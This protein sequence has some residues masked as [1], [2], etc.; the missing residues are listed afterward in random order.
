V[1]FGRDIADQ[2]LVAMREL[3]AM[4]K[5]HVTAHLSELEQRQSNRGRH[6]ELTLCRDSNAAHGIPILNP[7][8]INE[9]LP[10]HL[11]R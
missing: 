7:A 6:S 9:L 4:R 2:P 10:E 11:T 5:H 3:S 1:L 8:L